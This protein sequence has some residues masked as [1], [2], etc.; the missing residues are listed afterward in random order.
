MVS[1]DKLLFLCSSHSLCFLHPQ[2]VT[3]PGTAVG[4]EL[5]KMRRNKA[6]TERPTTLSAQVYFQSLSLLHQGVKKESSSRDQT[7]SCN[8]QS[9]DPHSK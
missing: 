9:N 7:Q 2:I 4:Q 1:C 3:N 5:G 6:G 8:L